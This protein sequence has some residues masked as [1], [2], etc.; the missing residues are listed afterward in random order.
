[1]EMVMINNNRNLQNTRLYE[2][3]DLLYYLKRKN[4][5]SDIY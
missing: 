2:Q 3:K 4:K 5:T 1:M